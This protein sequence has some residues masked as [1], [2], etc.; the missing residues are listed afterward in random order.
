MRNGFGFSGQLMNP[1]RHWNFLRDAFHFRI[2]HS[3]IN[4]LKRFSESAFALNQNC[5]LNFNPKPYLLG[6]VY[7]LSL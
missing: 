1:L 5:A 6:Y 4:K 7:F 3:V 2:T